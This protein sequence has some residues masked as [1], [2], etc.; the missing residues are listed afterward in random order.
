MTPTFRDDPDND[1]YVAEVAGEVAAFTNY[2][3]VRDDRRL[4]D[5]T[6]TNSGYEGQGVASQLV[7]FALDD[8]RAKGYRI[9]PQCPFVAGFVDDHPQYEDLVDREM[10]AELNDDA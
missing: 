8:M 10:L 5:H 3:V 2:H 9:V 7:Q 6:V 1:R 4:F